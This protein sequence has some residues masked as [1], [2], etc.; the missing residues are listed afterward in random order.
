MFSKTF[1]NRNLVLKG[2]VVL[3]CLGFSLSCQNEEDALQNDSQAKAEINRVNQLLQ[4][5]HDISQEDV[6]SIRKIYADYPG[7]E[8]ARKTLQNSLV[9]REDWASLESF[10]KEIPFSKL[11]EEDKLN[12]A[13]VNIKLGRY[14]DSVETLKA[15]ENQNNLEVKSLLANAN[16]HLGKY[17]EAKEPLDNSWDRVIAA[18]KIDD[19]VLRGMIY[20]YEKE[21]EKAI[22]T[23]NQALEIDPKNVAANNALSRVY[24]AQGNTEK[25]E[26][27]LAK[28]QNIFDKTTAEEKRK[29]NLVERLY[30]LQ[31]AYK[32]K[33]YQ[34]VIVLAE[35][36]LPEA[37]PQNKAVVYQYLYNSYQAL[38]KSKEAQEVLIKAK[39]IQQK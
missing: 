26:E 22:E 32:A 1:L 14:A 13:K 33:R 39:Q 37:S 5:G 9:R 25:A 15:V 16:F 20:F 11:S 38:G 4:V 35:R 10:F 29:A 36:V 24:A 6:D 7:S 19:V 23:L 27:Y 3:L 31:D 2:F 17:A 28:V 21:N 34:E 8:T 30:K 12:F 18:K